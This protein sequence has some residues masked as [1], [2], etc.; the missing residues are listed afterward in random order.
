MKRTLGQLAEHAGGRVCGDPDIVIHSV[1]T[2][3]KAREGDISFLA[4]RRYTQQFRNTKA[5][6]V[7]VSKELESKAALLVVDDP[8]Y[9][10]A[11]ILILY[12]GHRP[13]KKTGISSKAA[14]SRTAVLGK[15][16]HIGDFVTVSDHAR[17]GDR[18]VV[19]PG[20]FIGAE[21]E[22]GDDCVLYP[23][24]VV[25]ERCRIGNRVNIQ[26]NSTV[27]ED[28][29]G[30]ATHDGKHHKMPHIGRV[31]IEDDV[32]IGSGCAI[33]RGKLGDTV[34]GRGSKIGDLVV[35][36]HAT[37]LGPHCLLVPQVGIAGS[38]T[39]G[40]HCVAGGQVGITDHL[41][42]GNGVIMAAQSGVGKDFADGSVV[43]GS[44]AFEATRAKRAYTIIKYLPEMRQGLRKLEERVSN[45]EKAK[46]S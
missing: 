3:E 1:S 16:T 21:A 30:Y 34:I 15:D 22:V 20:V 19:Y 25:Y 14:I 2:L 38:T 26:A 39:L 24:V 10:F 36:G 5:S 41:K 42:I 45:L 29:F 6:A 46:K 27:G 28:G 17:I 9:A 37:K 23:N 32:E 18:C 13:H 33:E 7:I 4:H 8:Y 40:H 12:H 31:I 44:P 43:F 11:Q 35:I